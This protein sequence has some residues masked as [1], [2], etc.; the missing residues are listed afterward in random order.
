MI[1]IPLWYRQL[2]YRV[3]E[4]VRVRVEAVI[5]EK[6]P[7]LKVHVAAARLSADG[8]EVRGLSIAEPG[9]A[10]PQGELAFVDVMILKCRTS[11]QELLSGAPVITSVRVLRPVLRATRRPD[12]SYSLSK[13]FPL[14]KPPGP[15]PP[16]AIE[17]GRVEIFDPLRN[18]SS[19]FVLRD[20]NVAVQPAAEIGESWPK[21]NLQ[22]YMV[23]DHIR[24]IDLTATIDTKQD[25]WWSSGSV[26]GLDIS[27]EL[28]A[29]LPGNISER[30]EP[31]ASLRA[32]ASM[33]FKV[34]R[35]GD[36]A[37]RFEVTGSV[38]RGRIEDARLS[39]P[40]TDLKGDFHCDN[41]GVTVSDVT[42]RDGPTV[43]TMKRFRQDGY[44]PDSPF[45]LSASGRR[46]HVDDKW[47]SA[48]PEEFSKYW[49]YYEPEGEIDVDCELEFDGTKLTFPSLD[50]RCLDNVSF[51]F[52]KFPYRLERAHGS[53]TMSHGVLSVAMTAFAGSQSVSLSGSFLN[54]GPEFTGWLEIQADK[55]PLD[56]KLIA[57]VQ[58]TKAHETLVSLNPSGTFNVFAK[59][60]RNDP[61][62][63]KM[64]QYA[65]VT[66]VPANRCS[67][68]YERFPY[69]LSN[70]EGTLVLQDDVWTFDKVTG[71]NGP[72]SVV[73]SGDVSTLP[74]GSGANIDIQASNIQLV[75]E[76]RA[77]LKPEMRRLWDALQPHGKL[78][79][80]ANVRLAAGAEKPSVWL[81]AHPR[82]D[83]SSIGTSIEPVNFP[84]RMRLLSGW[85]DYC[86]G[87]ADLHQFHAVHGQ[88]QMRTS[89]SA[90]VGADGSWEL[91]LH[92]LSVDRLRLGGDDHELIAAL[93]PALRRA[94]ASLKPTAP[95]NLIGAAPSPANAVIFAKRGPDADL[96]SSWDVKL[97]THCSNVQAGPLLED[98][99]GRV[100][101]RGSASGSRYSSQGELDI[102]SVTYKNFQFTEVRG[103]L[104]FDNANI[105]LGA[106]APTTQQAA[107]ARPR[108]TARLLG[109][110]LAGDGHVRLGAVPQ[111]RMNASL[112]GADLG[113]FAREN[114]PAG[115]KLEGKIAGQLEL[116]GTPGPRNLSGS[117][118]LHLSE[119]DVYTLPVMVSLLSLLRAKPPDSTA[120]T[121]SDIA[122][123]IQ[124]GE[125]LILKRINLDGDAVSLS[126]FGTLHLDGQSNPIA[127][128]LHAASGSG[129]LPVLSGMLSEASQQI[130]LIHVDGTLEHPQTRAEPFP[131]ANQ[132]LQQLQADSSNK[133]PLLGSG[134]FMRALGFRR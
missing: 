36:E 99:F 17:D 81:R 4:E 115:Q 39:Y 73:I 50:V 134:D 42:A 58:P 40:L 123:D 12:G 119:A 6:L 1:A 28:R 43:W 51:E 89:G 34:S 102:D 46:V 21:L 133:P 98:V 80:T 27:P 132:A 3:E 44:A 129:G 121:Q 110:V 126:G 111:Y 97:T 13:L 68:T 122:F 52:H 69:R 54:P 20:I 112:S 33:R 37:P 62:L 114:L 106:M 48:L 30:L 9:A 94:V 5:A 104:W 78:D 32:P 86:N 118:S 64:K 82:D 90:D 125:H 71:K 87:H 29:S 92:D 105:Y 25:T 96:F 67:V 77:A 66:L 14:P 85:V 100:R 113:Q 91:R 47:A 108:V 117:G 101:L 76:L 59:L 18:P 8:I 72:G 55:I 24:R 35:R 103:P 10:G 53:L 120:F 45:K 107:G 49:Y 131:V 57:A 116:H 124:Q 19:N 79:A 74:D 84:Y 23:A 93:P 41:S 31:L 7:H 83:A 22:G 127:L 75:E 11:P 15:P 95:I 65:R 128:Q 109:G 60:W 2:F 26:D 38:S 88:T 56:E 61:R 16:A 70:L 63:P 130:L